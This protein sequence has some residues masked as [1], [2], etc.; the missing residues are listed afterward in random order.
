MVQQVGATGAGLVHVPQIAR[1]E[2]L[3]TTRARSVSCWWIRTRVWS[4]LLCLRHR[5]KAHAERMHA[6][7]FSDAVR[8][9]R[10]MDRTL[11]EIRGG[12]E[13]G[14]TVVRDNRDRQTERDSQR[15]L[16]VSLCTVCTLAR[17][18]T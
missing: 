5:S 18:P 11:L 9:T 13:E 8:S 3:R 1:E 2:R 7:P 10:K 4:L 6:L 14:L 15:H 12:G 17:G 16:I